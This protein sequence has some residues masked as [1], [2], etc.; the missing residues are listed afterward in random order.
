MPTDLALPPLN[1]AEA[2]LSVKVKKPLVLLNSKLVVIVAACSA[3]DVLSNNSKEG[4]E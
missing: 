4:I 2:S 1:V 3:N